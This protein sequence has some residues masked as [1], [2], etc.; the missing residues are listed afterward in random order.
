L[1]DKNHNFNLNEVDIDGKDKKG[2]DISKK[3]KFIKPKVP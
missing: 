1:I 3:Y 2:K